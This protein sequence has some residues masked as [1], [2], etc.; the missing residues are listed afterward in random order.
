MDETSAECGHQA[1]NCGHQGAVG[2]AGRTE[3]QPIPPETRKKNN[4]KVKD[5]AVEIRLRRQEHA[6]A[7]GRRKR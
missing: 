6:A 2:P 4:P 1:C 3:P 5:W 7:R